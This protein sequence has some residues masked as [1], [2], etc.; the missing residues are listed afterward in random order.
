ML[1]S[2]LQIEYTYHVG[3]LITVIKVLEQ[4]IYLCKNEVKSVV[5]SENVWEAVINVV[6]SL[7]SLV[8][9]FYLEKP[10]FCNHHLIRAWPASISYLC[11][12]MWVLV[13]RVTH[14]KSRTEKPRVLRRDEPE[15]LL[16]PTGGSIIKRKR[17]GFRD[18]FLYCDADALHTLSKMERLGLWKTHACLTFLLV[19][20]ILTPY[21]ILCKAFYID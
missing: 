20:L 19:S 12:Y 11:G 15:W 13:Q 14:K 3:C 17:A 5:F 2:V 7:E 4:I 1:L 16:Y 8:T 6:D 9:I 18:V 21:Q 10:F